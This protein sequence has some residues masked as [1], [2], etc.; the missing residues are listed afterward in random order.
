MS[1]G[2]VG[3]YDLSK[4]INYFREKKMNPALYEDVIHIT[5]EPNQH[6]H[7]LH[8]LHH[9]HT[10]S[11]PDI[12]TH[13]FVSVDKEMFVFGDGAIVCWGMTE[14][15]EKDWK[16]KLSSFENQ[17]S[18]HIDLPL[19]PHHRHNEV[20]TVCEE[21]DFFRGKYTGINLDRIIL[22]DHEDSRTRT[23]KQLAFSYGIVRSLKLEIVEILMD[24]I[25][26][27]VQT[28]PQKLRSGV[29]PTHL[30][31]PLFFFFFPPRSSG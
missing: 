13:D 20:A 11:A 9:H 24:S 29:L 12:H 15:E 23:K 7:H 8:H 3:S 18:I 22:N 5:I 16:E 28:I 14:A 21:I 31:C 10:H 17:T 25:L 1:Y 6:D 4:L 19:I 30:V 2:T 26:D 27:R